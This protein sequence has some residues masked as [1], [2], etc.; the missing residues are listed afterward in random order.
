MADRLEHDQFEVANNTRSRNTEVSG[1]TLDRILNSFS[2]NGTITLTIPIWVPTAL[3][4]IYVITEHLWPGEGQRI[5]RS[6]IA[7]FRD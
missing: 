6:L 3:L 1:T 4:L 7:L 2:L 5:A